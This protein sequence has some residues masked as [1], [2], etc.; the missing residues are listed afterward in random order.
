MG[1]ADAKV[2][3]N[4]NIV[5]HIFFLIYFFFLFYVGQVNTSFFIE[6]KVCD[7]FYVSQTDTLNLTQ[8][9][10]ILTDVICVGHLTD[11]KILTLF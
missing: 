11:T 8:R 4:Q 1:Q 3:V 5:T 6:K 10:V 2:N 7:N 9:T